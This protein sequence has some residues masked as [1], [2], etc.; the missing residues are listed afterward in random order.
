VL[1]TTHQQYLRL[2]TLPAANDRISNAISELPIFPH[3]SFDLETM[4]ASVDGQKF[5]VERNRSQ[6]RIESYHQLS[7]AIAQVGGKREL[8]GRTNLNIEISNQCT[9]LIA[10]AIVHYNSAIL[11]R[12]PTVYKASGNETALALITSTSPAAWRHVHLS[13]R[14]ALRDGAQVIDLD[15]IIRGLNR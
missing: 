3:C 7:S 8:A 9:R 5:G 10:N 14:Y 2:A 11:S 6:N 1:E 15:T 12:L 13:R 4:Y